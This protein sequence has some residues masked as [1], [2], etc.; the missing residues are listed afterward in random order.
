MRQTTVRIDEG[1]HGVLK[2]I[3]QAER[4]PLGFVIAEAVEE[5]RRRRFLEAVNRGYE[6]ARRSPAWEGMLAE[7]AEWDYALADGLA[8]SR[9]KTTRRRK[10]GKRKRGAPR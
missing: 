8:S 5:L 3:A 4:H 9:A 7:R 1:T 6:E 10:S 2:K